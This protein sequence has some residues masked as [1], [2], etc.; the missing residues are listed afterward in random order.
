MLHLGNRP[1]C[2]FM[3]LQLLQEDVNVS[4]RH[5]LTIWLVFYKHVICSL[6]SQH[7][8]LLF[9]GVVSGCFRCLMSRACT[10]C[11]GVPSD[12]PLSSCCEH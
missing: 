11:T 1:F 2:D 4:K 12:L 6:C 3:R 10:K 7:W 5:A 8:R 9:C